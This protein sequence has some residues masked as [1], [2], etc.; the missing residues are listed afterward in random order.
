M[1]KLQCEL[2]GSVDIVKIGDDMF[3]CQ[4]CGCK[5]TAA[6]AKK[7]L[8]GEVTF[9]AQDFEIVGGKLVK[10]NGVNVEVD[11]PGLE[12]GSTGLPD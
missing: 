8:F 11:I 5:Y 12:I 7:I 10:Y 6:E 1:N 4:H 9:K 3:Q 2:C